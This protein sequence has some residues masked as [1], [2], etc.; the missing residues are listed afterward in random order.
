MTTLLEKAFAQVQQLPDAE[1]DAVA[2]RLLKTLTD[3][4]QEKQHTVEYP[5]SPKRRAGTAKGTFWM[6]EDFD[7]P[8]EDFKDYM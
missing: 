1:Q 2:E 5:T 8:L 4:E 3:Y 7:A 6:S